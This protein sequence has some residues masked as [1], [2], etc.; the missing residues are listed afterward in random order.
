VDSDAAKGSNVASVQ[1][2][3]DV[4]ESEATAVRKRKV[5]PKAETTGRSVR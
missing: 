2:R 4:G 5:A 1:V 3:A